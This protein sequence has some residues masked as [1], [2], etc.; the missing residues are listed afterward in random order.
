M[1]KARGNEFF[2]IM[3]YGLDAGLVGYL[4]A[5]FFV[6]VLYY[7]FFWV[8][9]AMTVAANS[10]VKGLPEPKTTGNQEAHAGM[11]ARRPGSMVRNN[12]LLPA[13]KRLDS[14]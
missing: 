7:P 11:H 9:M 2:Y 14:D 6:T 12:K 5:G 10:I 4:V 13:R 3:A 8:Q 1:A